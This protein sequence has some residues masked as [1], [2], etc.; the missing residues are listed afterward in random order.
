MFSLTP[1][2]GQI[3]DSLTC[4]TNTELKLIASKIIKANECETILI[5]TELQN[6]NLEKQ[7][8]NLEQ[9]LLIKDSIISGKE[10]IISDFKT[11]TQYKD[12]QLA[13]KTNETKRLKKQLFW[14]RSGW[15]ASTLGLLGTIL[16]LVL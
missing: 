9:I 8:C 10:S 11:M 12:A 2:F 13:D 16:F 4:Y 14:T 7:L 6:Q 15:V 5:V 1:L 3:G